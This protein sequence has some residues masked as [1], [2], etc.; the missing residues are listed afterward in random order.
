MCGEHVLVFFTLIMSAGS[1]PHVRGARRWR[2]RPSSAAGI[3]PACAGSTADP[4][5]RTTRNGDHPRMCG[6]HDC[7]LQSRWRCMGSSPH[8]RGAH[9]VRDLVGRVLGI[10][11]ACAGS[12]LDV[13]VQGKPGKDHPRMCGE[14][15]FR[16][17]KSL[18]NSGSSPHVRGALVIHHAPAPFMRDHPRMCGEHW[19]LSGQRKRPWGSSPHVRGALSGLPVVLAWRGIIP[20][21]AGSTRARRA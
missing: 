20:A 12:T 10:I 21:C 1:S 13:V 3:I 2:R 15:E 9:H 14:H 5:M 16:T 17:G 6:E 11:P 7:G 18:V 8:V 4:E 19:T